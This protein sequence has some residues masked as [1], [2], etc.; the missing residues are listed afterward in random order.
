MHANC[1]LVFD[2]TL[3]LIFEI[4]FGPLAQTEGDCE[5]KDEREVF[6]LRA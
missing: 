6:T 5:F 3:A 2:E 1:F 4:L